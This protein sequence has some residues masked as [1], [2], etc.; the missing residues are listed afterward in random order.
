MRNPCKEVEINGHKYRLAERQ[1]GEKLVIAIVDNR[2]LTFIGY[3]DF[4]SDN[5]QITIRDARCLVTWGTNEHLA[6][7][8]DGP[9]SNTKLGKKADVTVFR[10]QLVL[11]Y[12]VD[13]KSW[14]KF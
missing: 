8:I 3:A 1:E 9:L 6:Q 2:G 5:E 4:S 14:G 11:F 13:E 10:Q 12:E 7:L